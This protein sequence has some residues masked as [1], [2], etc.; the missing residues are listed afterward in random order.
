MPMI[1]AGYDRDN[2]YCSGIVELGG[3][4][5]ATAQILGVD[6]NHPENIKNGTPVVAE[7]VERGAWAIVG[8]LAQTQKTYLAFKAQQ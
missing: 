2:P 7:F 3:G 6:V 5:K 8:E 4:L 1:N